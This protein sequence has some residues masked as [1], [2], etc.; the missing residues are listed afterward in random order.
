MTINRYGK[1]IYSHGRDASWD[2]SDWLLET[3]NQLKAWSDVYWHV[4]GTINYL[5]CSRCG[6]TFPCVELANC[7][8]HPEEA[9]FDPAKPMGEYPCC[10]LKVMRFDPLL[11][12]QVSLLGR[13]Y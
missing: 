8:Y 7:R 9:F 6:E 5:E 3:R 1:F 4:W 10:G 13:L 2:A 11:P 12:N